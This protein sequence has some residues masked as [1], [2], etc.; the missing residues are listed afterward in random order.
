[1]KA[2]D[3]IRRIKPWMLIIAMS[4]GALFHDYM[5][6]VAFLAPYL[7]FAMLLVTFCKV[8]FDNIRI[9]RLSWLLAAVQVLGGV[10]VYLGLLPVDRV[11]AQGAF[12][13]VFCP[14]ATAAPVIVG[15]LG[16]SIPRQATFAIVSNVAAAL[17]VP[18][19]FT[20]MG[21]DVHID[22]LG[23]FATIA[24]R[25]IPL[26]LAPLAVAMVLRRITPGVH[27][28]L[29][30]HQAI[31]FYIWS[32][33]LIIVVGRSVSFVMAEPASEIP[34]MVALALVALVLC[35]IQFAVGR[36]IGRRCG[37]RVVGAQGLAQKNTVLAVWM[38]WT[39]F[40]PVSSVAPAAYI[41][42]QNIINSIQLYLHG[43]HATQAHNSHHSYNS[44][45]S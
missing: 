14:T 19:L 36:A 28:Y 20:V 1:M 17:L 24:W 13:C 7:I 15:M 9:T 44:H 35:L 22:F 8:P 18:P 27:A 23:T 10:V 5:E 38:A 41:A 29:G 40:D 33:S 25:V 3:V 6:A 39:Y 26:I 4:T 31:S 2:N 11:V 45:L 30:R 37:D 21:S 12:I 34:R 43:R 32:V 16:G 42:W